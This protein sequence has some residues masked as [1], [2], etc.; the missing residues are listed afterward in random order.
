MYPPVRA[1]EGGGEEE[2]GMHSSILSSDKILMDFQ[3]QRLESAK[4]ELEFYLLL[5]FP[6]IS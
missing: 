5:L 4:L 1:R 6:T 2:M 3:V